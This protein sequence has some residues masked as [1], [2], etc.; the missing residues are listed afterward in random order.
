MSYGTKCP[1]VKL[2]HYPA[3]APACG[4]EPNGGGTVPCPVCEK[5][6]N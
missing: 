5:K 4:L 2:I 6:E 3:D 1:G